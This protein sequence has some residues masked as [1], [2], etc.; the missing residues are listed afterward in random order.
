MK[1]YLSGVLAI[2]IT[3]SMSTLSFARDTELAAK[4]KVAVAEFAIREN[5]VVSGR[6]AKEFARTATEKIIN[7]FAALKRFTILDRVSVTQLQR[8][9]QIQMLGNK[10]RAVNARLAAVGKADI[11]CVGEVQNVSVSEQYDSKGKFLGY[12]GEV[13]LQ[14]RLYDLATGSLVLSKDVRGGTEMGGGILSVLSLYQDT[15]SKAVFKALNNAER[16]IKDAIEEAFPVEG[17]I[18]EVIDASNEQETFLTTMGSELGF[19]SGDKLMVIEVSTLKVNGVSYPRQKEIGQLEITKVEPD[20]TFSEARVSGDGG[21]NIV[22]KY[23]SGANL[24]LRSVK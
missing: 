15:P 16:R 6:D 20:G 19:R 1:K 4:R 14:I 10:N 13:E 5:R 22:T 8:D 11:Y 9:K 17:K 21:Q 18:A 7:A 12:D 23:G 24:V 3:L 2:V